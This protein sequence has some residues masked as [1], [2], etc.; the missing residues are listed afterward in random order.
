[1]D[2]VTQGLLGAVIGQAGFRHRLGRRALL[3]GA[4]CGLAPDLDMLFHLGSPWTP[5]RDPPELVPFPPGP[6][7]G[8]APLRLARRPPPRRGQELPDLDPPGLLGPDHP[9]P[10]GS[11]HLLRDDAL[12]SPHVAPVRRRR[13]R[14]HRPSLFAPPGPGAPGGMPADSTGQGPGHRLGR[15]GGHHRLRRPGPL[16]RDPRRT[17]GPGRLGRR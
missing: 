3:F 7:P 9:S 11:F 1:M 8:G 10:P 2:T 17:A 5:V 4:A 14:Q 13:H 16:R 12:L 15:I 6:S